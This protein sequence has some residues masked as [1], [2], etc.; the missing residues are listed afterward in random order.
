MLDIDKEQ[1]CAYKLKEMDIIFNNSTDD[2]DKIS[3][4]LNVLIDIYKISSI[5]LFIEI[6]S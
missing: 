2:I 6:G 5:P 1:K 3:D 4:E